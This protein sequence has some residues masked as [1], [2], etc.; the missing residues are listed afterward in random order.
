MIGLDFRTIALDPETGLSI[1]KTGGKE[2]T[3]EATAGI[4]MRDELDRWQ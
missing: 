4:Q 2:I 1:G 3:L